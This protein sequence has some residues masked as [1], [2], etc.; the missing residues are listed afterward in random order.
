M[1]HSGWFQCIPY[2]VIAMLFGKGKADNEYGKSHKSCAIKNGKPL[3][4][5]FIVGVVFVLFGSVVGNRNSGVINDGY[6]ETADSVA[7]DTAAADS[8]Y[9]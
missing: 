7:V 8:A 9:Y 2:F 6:Y 3:L 5:I 1:G 4:V